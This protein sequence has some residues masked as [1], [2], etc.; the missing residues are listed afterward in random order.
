MAQQ[1]H[2]KTNKQDAQARQD[3]LD[4]L[5]PEELEKI[6]YHKASTE[7]RYKVDDHWLL[8]AEFAMAYGWQAYIDAVKKD[9][10][11]LA[12]MLTLVE[13]S[14]KIKSGYLYDMAH[15]SFIGATSSRAKK[16]NSV[17]SKFTKNIIKKTKPD[18]QE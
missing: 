18:K 9:K 16:P 3:A 6:K 14:R 8:I 7:G 2:Q 11:T 13:A 12:E 17:F 10:I 4:N 1:P 15:A 5:S